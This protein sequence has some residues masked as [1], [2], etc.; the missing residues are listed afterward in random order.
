MIMIDIVPQFCI[1][2]S[3]HETCEGM[4]PPSIQSKCALPIIGCEN[5]QHR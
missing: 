5:K 2:V 1:W 3:S 4:M